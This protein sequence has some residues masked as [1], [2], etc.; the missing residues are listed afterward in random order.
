MDPPRL[1]D[2]GTLNWPLLT[3]TVNGGFLT[4]TVD[5]GNSCSSGGGADLTTDSLLRRA[6]TDDVHYDPIVDLHL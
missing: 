6:N 1:M 5:T 3:L 2:I 4:L